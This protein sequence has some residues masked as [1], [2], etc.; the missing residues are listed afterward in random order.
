MPLKRFEDTHWFESC[1]PIEEI[2]RRGP[3]TLRIGPMKPKVCGTRKP[4]KTMGVCAASPGK[5]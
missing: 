1:L 2:A 4:A 5:I 3:E